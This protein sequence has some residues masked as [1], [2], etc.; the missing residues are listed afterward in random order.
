LLLNPT[1]IIVK[2]ELYLEKF[3]DIFDYTVQ[4]M[5]KDFPVICDQAL[6]FGS[7]E[8]DML[9]RVPHERDVVSLFARPFVQNGT[10]YPSWHDYRRKKYNYGN[11]GAHQ[12]HCK[13]PDDPPEAIPNVQTSSPGVMMILET[14]HTQVDL[15]LPDAVQKAIMDALTHES[16]GFHVTSASSF[17]M[18][19]AAAATDPKA[20]VIVIMHEGYVVARTWAAHR[21]CA[22][23]IHLWSRFQEM[24]GV[25]R[26]L[27][28]AMGSDSSSSSSKSTSAFRIVAGGVF[29]ID[30]WK[31]DEMNRGPR[32]T[33]DCYSSDTDTTLVPR[34][35]RMDPKAVR[36]IMEQT[37]ALM[38]NETEV[39]VVVLCGRRQS[40]KGA[41]ACESLDI[42][43]NYDNDSLRW[44]IIPLWTCPGIEASNPYAKSA[45]LAC[46]D[47]V[48]K[49]LHGI[50]KRDRRK[51]RALVVD[52]SVPQEFAQVIHRVFK[53][54]LQ[55]KR[56]MGDHM[57]V[58]APMVN[59]KETW[60]R[61]FLD[62]FRKEFITFEPVFRAEVFFNSSDSSMEMGV[63]SSGDYDFFPHFMAVV[64]DIEGQTGLISDVRNIQGGLFN[65]TPGFQP[66]LF[67][68]PQD[69]DQTGPLEQWWSQQ[70]L[71]H[72]TVFQLEVQPIEREI[73]EE[74][75]VMED[76]EMRKKRIP[77]KIKVNR[78]EP[79]TTLE[80]TAA[81]RHTLT[82]MKKE[83][84]S[85]AQTQEF[86][87]GDGYLWTA[88]WSGGNVL[89]L[90]DGRI[91]IAVNLFTY[92]ESTELAE[93]FAAHFTSKVPH[94]QIR[95]RDEQPRGYGRVVNF[96]KD[97]EPW[98]TPHWAAFL[99]K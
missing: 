86:K 81:L 29:G 58:M 91:H 39:T 63:T 70:P 3:S 12:K 80:I 48:W 57:L 61:A 42:L 41:A 8:N 93:E 50:V 19:A 62:R 82:S 90:W 59:E 35:K 31:D 21:Y 95:L 89:V 9:T 47:M 36:V 13:R 73:Y 25:K 55:R 7:Y 43:K 85:D 77:K 52:V 38:H 78:D 34:P 83:S 5:I 60:R 45:M 76:G 27:I 66:S 1:G 56:L 44:N 15:S 65:Y 4:L 87:V 2:N 37:L 53:N 46:E 28:A 94:L 51:I 98:R 14:E 18:D 69:Y 75:R 96:K 72:Q 26:A 23:D 32:Y 67:F 99:E 74:K 97:M 68:L 54:R 49:E 79:I 17:V 24:D 11:G 64:E 10:R 6:I 22:F 20:I 33:R 92:Q 40:E 88:L 30:T 16:V 84:M 71:G